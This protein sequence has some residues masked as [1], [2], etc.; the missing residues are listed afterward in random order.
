MKRINFLT[1]V[2]ATLVAG[3]CSNSK[4]EKNTEVVAQVETATVENTKRAK[5][6]QYTGIVQAQTQSTVGTRLMGQIENI[7]VKKGDRVKKGDLLVTLRSH[8]IE[9]KER[10]VEAQIA[11]AEAAF[12]NSEI[13]YNR[14]KNLYKKQSATR[15]EFDDI[16]ARYKMA[17]AR[18]DA[19]IQQRSEVSEQLQYARIRSPYNGIVINKFVNAGDMASPGMPLLAVEVPDA[20]EV[21]TRIPES[22][23]NLWKQGDTALVEIPSIKKKLKGIVSHISPSNKFSGPQYEI[24][25]TLQAEKDQSS[26]MRSGMF[27]NINLF[28]GTEEVVVVPTDL[29]VQRGQLTGIWMVSPQGKALMRWVRTGRESGDKTEILSGISAGESYIVKYDRRLFDGI[30]IEY[31]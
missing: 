7:Y 9:A 24:L 10:Q 4:K 15:L 13:N 8:S 2:V 26:M 3:S 31:Q 19:A 21:L 20:F 11:E 6:Y 29:F 27:A 5:A 18:L 12:A 22:E 30:K 1:I 17:K 23:M 28:S 16:E 14:M 25:I